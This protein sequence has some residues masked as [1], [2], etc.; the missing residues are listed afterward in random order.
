MS[1]APQTIDCSD[2]FMITAFPVTT[3]AAAMPQ[4]IAIG[5]FHGAITKATPRGQ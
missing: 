1:M 3:P 2:G 5:K 4:R